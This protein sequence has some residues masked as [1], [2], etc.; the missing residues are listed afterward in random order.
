[1]KGRMTFVLVI[2]FLEKKRK[3]QRGYHEN[4]PC[5]PS[6]KIYDKSYDTFSLNH[7]VSNHLKLIILNIF[8]T[9]VVFAVESF[10]TF[11]FLSFFIAN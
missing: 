6:Q 2:V 5:L 9:E 3:I 8:S 4:Y 1:M 11:S 10:Q 7:Q